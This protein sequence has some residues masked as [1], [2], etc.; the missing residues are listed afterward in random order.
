MNKK[1][2]LL[3]TILTACGSDD[4]S[5]TDCTS[6]PLADKSIQ[7]DDGTM[8]RFSKTCTYTLS[9]CS[10]RGTYKMTG[11]DTVRFYPESTTCGDTEPVNCQF[12]ISGTRVEFA[13]E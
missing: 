6:S 4:Q 11:S 5:S 13:C 2:I 10:E 12:D 9:T 1:I 8:A 7:L 3:A